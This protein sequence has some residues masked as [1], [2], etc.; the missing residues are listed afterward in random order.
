MP[1][2]GAIGKSITR[3]LTE[4]ELY[5]ELTN[6]LDKDVIEELTSKIKA[7][8]SKI[9]KENAKNYETVGI[10]TTQEVRG[11][12]SKQKVIGQGIPEEELE[13]GPI[14]SN[15]L[16]LKNLDIKNTQDLAKSL[17]Y[18]ITGI[19]AGKELTG[20]EYKVHFSSKK[21]SMYKIIIESDFMRELSP[22][23]KVRDT[24][25]TVVKEAIQAVKKEARKSKALKKLVASIGF[26]IV[27][28]G[29]GVYDQPLIYGLKP[30]IILGT[31]PLYSVQMIERAKSDRKLKNRALGDV[32]LAHQKGN[33]DVLRVDATLTGS[34]RFIY[35]TYLIQLQIEGMSKKDNIG[36]N[37]SALATVS[38][39]GG[40]NLALVDKKILN[41]DVHK[42]FPIITRTGVLFN[43][44]LQTIEWHQSVEDGKGVIKVHLLFRKYFPTSG[45]KVLDEI[46]SEED[47]GVII[48]GSSMEVIEDYGMAKRWME[49][50]VDAIWKMNKY[51]GEI[52]GRMLIG[53]DGQTVFD[54]DRQAQSSV[55]KLIT[56]YSGKLFGII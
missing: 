32:F 36:L 2:K 18:F 54:I 50:T 10:I 25:L 13:T 43:M 11:T 26:G 23:S 8:L 33:K 31:V 48:G 45:F 51:F 40:S 29:G 46:W 53:D 39:V 30:E 16:A 56:S 14:Q 41:Y 49:Y 47:G 4:K 27:L 24:D 1:I 12:P 42:T 20:W 3:E 37:P 15:R 5:K 6:Y 34:Y 52:N 38:G 7:G 55:D 35:L 44:Y 28:M 9:Y 19:R 17:V 21:K 22:V